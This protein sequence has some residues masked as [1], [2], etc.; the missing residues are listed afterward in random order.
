MPL[1]LGTDALPADLAARFAALRGPRPGARVPTG[2]S[3]SEAGTGQEHDLL[4]ERL[5][6]L[7]PPNEREGNR[8]GVEVHVNDHDRKDNFFATTALSESSLDTLSGVEVQ[9][10]KRPSLGGGG[11]IEEA[12]TGDEGD[13]LIRRMLDE[14]EVEDKASKRNEEGVKDWES[15]MDRLRRVGP[16]SSERGG[17]DASSSE[18]AT[19][20]TGTGTVDESVPAVG[21]LEDELKRRRKRE[22]K[23]LK[24][25]GVVRDMPGSDRDSSGDSDDDE[26]SSESEQDDDDDDTQSE[27]D[28][29]DW[30]RHGR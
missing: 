14:V 18:Q 3:S 12:A 26:T 21:D 11:G 29:I 1:N 13:E 17:P 25:K 10:M 22:E 7:E 28:G 15:R 9:F 8:R 19:A 24:K 5:R 2:P 30:S 6:K 23:K 4:E 27:E 16:A 20:G